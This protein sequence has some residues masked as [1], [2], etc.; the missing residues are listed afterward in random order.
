MIQ[1][2]V[3]NYCNRNGISC[4][5]ESDTCAEFGAPSGMVFSTESHYRCV[6]I[7]D[8]LDGRLKRVMRASD[9]IELLSLYPDGKID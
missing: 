8:Y 3:L 4:E 7:G 5:M 6:E 2:T 1:K 9:V